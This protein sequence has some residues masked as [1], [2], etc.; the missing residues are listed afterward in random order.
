M[1]MLVAGV[2]TPSL[3]KYSPLP[4]ERPEITA[5]LN[6]P[7]ER[8]VLLLVTFRRAARL[9]NDSTRRESLLRRR[10]KSSA[11]VASEKEE[12]ASTWDKWR[13]S[14]VVDSETVFKDSDSDSGDERIGEEG[15]VLTTRVLYWEEEEEAAE[16][17]ER[18]RTATEKM[19][20]FWTF[21][22]MLV[23]KI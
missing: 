16:E 10:L 3:M 4:C 2:P 6:P 7:E 18:K 8:G 1:Y 19:R 21:L 14:E 12:I 23:L 22:P 13:E 15:R 20:V 5:P 9:V 17:S 11:G